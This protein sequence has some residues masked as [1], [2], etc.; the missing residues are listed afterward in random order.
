MNDK[1]SKILEEE[2]KIIEKSNAHEFSQDEL[3]SLIRSMP[4]YIKKICKL[5]KN[6]LERLNKIKEGQKSKIHI[7]FYRFKEESTIERINNSLQRFNYKFPEFRSFLLKYKEKNAKIIVK[8]DFNKI[9]LRDLSHMPE[10][11]KK[12]I[13]GNMI[14]AIKKS[15]YN[16]YKK[17]PYGI[18]FLKLAENDYLCIFSLSDDWKYMASDNGLLSELFRVKDCVE[19]DG[20]NSEMAGFNKT[21]NYWKEMQPPIQNAF[22]R[23]PDY[24]NKEQIETFELDNELTGL[25]DGLINDMHISISSVLYTI[26]GVILGKYF[27]NQN[28]AIGSVNTTGKLKLAPVM[29]DTEQDI[30]KNLTEVNHQL[31]LIP[32]ANGCSIEEIKQHLQIDENSKLP[33]IQEIVNLNKYVTWIGDMKA[34]ELY[35]LGVNNYENIPLLLINTLLD[36]QFRMEYHYQEQIFSSEDISKLHECFVHILKDMLYAIE[37]RSEIDIDVNRSH[38]KVLKENRIRI[39][40][41]LKKAKLFKDMDFN[42]LL[43]IAEKCS[44]V[45]CTNEEVVV[46]QNT[47]CEQLYI[48]GDGIIESAAA[49]NNNC[50]KSLKILKEGEMFGL[51]SLV[52]NQISKEQFTVYSN[53]A[54][55]VAIPRNIMKELMQTNYTIQIN[56]LEYVM[57]DVDRYKKLWLM[58]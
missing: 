21:L 40:L 34:D 36:N 57:Y 17:F 5:E 23:F 20:K 58:E 44:L 48:I 14:F 42:Y 30:K 32:E 22:M 18:T 13:L 37:N 53:F 43:Q 33:M 49:D 8:A 46:Q 35:H 45:T 16:I 41:Y 24:D 56:L 55:C 27:K 15:N 52:E 6:D 31:K 9:P 54:A 10:E 29:V 3:L 12:N 50:W 4:D 26:W 51:E 25:I 2:K 1:N 47:Y 19:L 38:D 28:I 11:M 7:Y 39:A